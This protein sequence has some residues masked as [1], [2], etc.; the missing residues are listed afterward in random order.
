ML[1]LTRKATQSIIIGD[2]IRVKVI[3][4]NMG[5]V[6]IGIEAPKDISVHRE[7]IYMKVVLERERERKMEIAREQMRTN[8]KYIMPNLSQKDRDELF[9][10]GVMD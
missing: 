3:R 8:N 2:N 10:K 1:L 4:M 7:E 9:G 5:Q 6:E